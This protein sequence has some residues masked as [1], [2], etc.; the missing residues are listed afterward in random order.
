MRKSILR[1]QARAVSGRGAVLHASAVESRDRGILFLAP[2]GGGKSTAA[3]ILGEAG[4]RVLGDDSTVVCRGTDGVWR[5]IPCASWS[6]QSEEERKAAP[7]GGLV[8]LEKGEP[9][10]LDG[11]APVY[12]FYRI[13][14]E[15]SIMAHG[16]VTP[17]ERPPFRSS[18]REI[19]RNFPVHLLRYSLPESLARMVKQL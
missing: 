7:L 14:R 6:W 4:Y 3:R 1:V 9:A 10:L 17:A 12:A 16:D 19:C 11:V 13:L 2:S 15:N 5:V 8:L 18:L